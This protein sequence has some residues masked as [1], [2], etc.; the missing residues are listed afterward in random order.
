MGRAEAGR[1]GG[2]TG[3]TLSTAMKS[4]QI[5]HILMSIHIFSH[6]AWV[7]PVEREVGSAAAPA[8]PKCRGQG[9]LGKAG[10]GGN[11]GNFAVVGVEVVG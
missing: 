5:K 4:K 6:L 1:A 11:V 10:L 9:E 8:K 3:S 2:S 7:E